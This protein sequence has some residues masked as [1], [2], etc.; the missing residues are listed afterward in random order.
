MEILNKEKETPE[1]REASDVCRLL[2][3]AFR[4]KENISNLVLKLVV[5]C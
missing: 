3:F 5:L 4:R 2:M 1:Q